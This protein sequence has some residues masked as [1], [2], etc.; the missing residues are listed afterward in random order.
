MQRSW[1]LG[2]VLLSRVR[3]TGEGQG[4]VP[5]DYKLRSAKTDLFYHKKAAG[6]ITGEGGRTY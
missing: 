2:R 4:R 1:G 6:E 5:E 3:D